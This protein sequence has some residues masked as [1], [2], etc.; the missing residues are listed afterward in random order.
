MN[1]FQNQE[2]TKQC[3]EINLTPRHGKVTPKYTIHFVRRGDGPDAHY[4]A[5]LHSKQPQTLAELPLTFSS[6]VVQSLPKCPSKSPSHERKKLYRTSAILTDPQLKKT[7][8]EE[9]QKA[10]KKTVTQNL[11]RVVSLGKKN[12]PKTERRQRQMQRDHCHTKRMKFALFGK[13]RGEEWIEC[14]DCKNLAH[15]ACAGFGNSP[16]Y[17]SL[18]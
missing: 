16:T 11:H 17:L 14:T 6:E 13:G 15:V 7:A 1:I 4:S 3:F 18:L 2:E 10:V 8:L 12:E 9:E 5:L